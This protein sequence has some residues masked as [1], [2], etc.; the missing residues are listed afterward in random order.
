MRAALLLLPLL[1]AACE[2]EPKFEDRYDQA[3]KE[4]E[5]R[6]KAMDADIAAADKA[7]KD[8]GEEAPKALPAEAPPATARPSSGE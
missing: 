6:A 3:A 8:A 4:I 5:A 7:A 2:K 1:L